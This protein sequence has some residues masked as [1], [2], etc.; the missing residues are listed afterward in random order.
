VTEPDP[1]ERCVDTVGRILS[2]YHAALHLLDA[3]PSAPAGEVLA[4]VRDACAGLSSLVAL[5]D[6][7]MAGTTRE[8]IAATHSRLLRRR[9]ALVRAAAG[10]AAAP[11]LEE[12]ERTSHSA[13]A[14][15]RRLSG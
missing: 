15:F 12:L 11:R 7:A 6:E 10:T 1:A 2:N 3:P 9:A 14:L 13:G 8:Q 4:P 5:V